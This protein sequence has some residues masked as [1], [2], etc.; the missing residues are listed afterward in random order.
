MDSE[1]ESTLP[2]N[3]AATSSS[4]LTIHFKANRRQ[5]VVD[6]EQDSLLSGWKSYSSSP[7]IVRQQPVNLI[8]S[9]VLIQAE[10]GID[11]D[12]MNETLSINSF[13]DNE[14][15][16]IDSNITDKDKSTISCLT[17]KKEE[18]DYNRAD[19]DE[20]LSYSYNSIEKQDDFL[21]NLPISDNSAAIKAIMKDSK[22]QRESSQ[23]TAGLRDI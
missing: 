23:L 15:Q 1:K 12:K 22:Q 20:Y 18:S 11:S 3:E 7:P 14:N 13:L 6:S 16:K 17:D 5:I 19:K 21:Q 4:Q 2:L 8:R 10:E 9:F